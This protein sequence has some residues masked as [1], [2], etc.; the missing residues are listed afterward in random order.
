MSEQ[1]H[2]DNVE[3]ESPRRDG[4]WRLIIVIAV[5]TAIGVWLVP[6]QTPP[7]PDQPPAGTGV[8]PAAPSL[9]P[10]EEPPAARPDQQTQT[11]AVS[12]TAA[13]TDDRPGAMARALIAE[14]RA[15]D[16][17]DLNKLYETARTAQAEGRLSDAYLLYF[18]SSRFGHAESALQ[19]AAQADPA[20]RDPENSVF[21]EPDLRQ[22]HKWYQVAAQYGSAE[23]QAQLDSLQRRIEKMAADGDQ[24]AQRISLLWQ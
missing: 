21:A 18:F 24:T 2:D 6:S 10:V 5:I 4:P 11:P 22:A 7:E 20:T 8:E 19:L 1:P 3:L 15:G 13:P 17:V 9:L 23:G 16:S 14:A 12:P